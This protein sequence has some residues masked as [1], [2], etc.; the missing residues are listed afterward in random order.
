LDARCAA[1]DTRANGPGFLTGRASKTIARALRKHGASLVAPPRSFLTKGNKLVAGELEGA[2][3]WGES[4][5]GQLV[6]VPMP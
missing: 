5:A 4:L 1:F 2:S 3:A 6:A